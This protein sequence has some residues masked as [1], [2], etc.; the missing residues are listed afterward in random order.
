MKLKEILYG[1]GLRPPAR[2]YSFEPG[3]VCLAPRGEIFFARWS[4]PKEHRKEFSQA[5]V[6]A[7]RGFLR[8]G[9]C[10]H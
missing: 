2:E 8:P 6:D 3:L 1:L 10:R 9:G 7:L 5:A 4:H